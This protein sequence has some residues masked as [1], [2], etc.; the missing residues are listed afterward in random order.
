[1]LADQGQCLST[2]LFAESAKGGRGSPT[3]HPALKQ[4]DVDGLRSFADHI[5]LGQAIVHIEKRDHD[6]AL[7]QK[8]PMPA[9]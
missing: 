1:M 8:I 5:R 4:F 2:L 3:N 9:D 6:A 7:Q